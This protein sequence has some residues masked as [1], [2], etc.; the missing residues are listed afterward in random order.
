M[1]TLKT[2]TG[3]SPLRSV[4]RK[5][6]VASQAPAVQGYL[7]RKKTPIPL[8]PPQDPRLGPTVGSY[9]LAVSYKRGTPLCSML[10]ARLKQAKHATSGKAE[11]PGVTLDPKP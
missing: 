8:G 10:T 4:S 9:C 11:A 5:W 2:L 7:A 3:S 6:R 1:W